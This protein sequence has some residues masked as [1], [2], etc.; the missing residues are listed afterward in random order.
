MKASRYVTMVRLLVTINEPL[1]VCGISCI[2]EMTCGYLFDETPG[3]HVT[4]EFAS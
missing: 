2:Q 4:I 1:D 3:R